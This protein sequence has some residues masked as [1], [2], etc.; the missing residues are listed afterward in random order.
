MELHFT[1]VK[2]TKTCHVFENGT[3]P[4]FTTL[5]L[6]KFQIEAAGINPKKGLTVKIEETR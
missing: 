6:K 2:D 4:E 1:Y 3:K 5:Y